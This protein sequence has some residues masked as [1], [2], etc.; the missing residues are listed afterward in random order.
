MSTDRYNELCTHIPGDLAGRI[1]KVL[2]DHVG[3]KR[4]IGRRELVYVLG[5]NERIL[6]ETIRTLRRN[7]ALICSAPGSD[8]GYWL[9]EDWAE[10][11]NF[12]ASELHSRSMDLLQTEQAMRETARLRFGE[13][14][15]PALLEVQ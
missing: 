6:R 4:A 12:C 5:V 10:V 14:T 1:V 3:R 15:Q 11:A 8:G 9:A 7:G 2:L 13:A